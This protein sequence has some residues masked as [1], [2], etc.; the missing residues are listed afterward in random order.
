MRWR[1][2]T[3]GQLVRNSVEL[4]AMS[5]VVEFTPGGYRFIP[6][7]FQ[8][9]AGVAALPGYRI[10]RETFAEPVPVAEGFDM[11][12]ARFKADG[13][14]MT[15]F[16]A[17]ELRSPGQFTDS[18]FRAFNEL[19]VVTLRKWGIMEA[20]SDVNP[21]ARS[22]VCPDIGAPPEPSFYAFSY[23]VDDA[24]AAPSAVT[25]G[26]AEAREGAGPYAER[27]VR[28]DETSDDAIRE[29]V[30]YVVDEM[31]RRLALLGF[32]WQ[33]TT[34]VQAYSVRDFH[35]V[36]AAMA[37]RKVLRK[38]LTWHYARPP[39]IGLDYEMDCRVVHD[40]RSWRPA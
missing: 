10:V 13:L 31:Q 28:L 15:R 18:G 5:D 34:T 1:A 21:V 3:I 4:S 37:E 17:C 6:S 32:G 36:M 14:A 26:G 2:C 22:N 25:S 9:S 12:E 20:G 29:K 24:G 19:Y 27:I 33:D 40:E 11:I 7:V 23:I 16:C 8:Y 38:G 35:H 39:V 30:L